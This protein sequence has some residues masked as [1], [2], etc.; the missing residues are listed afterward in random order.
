MST[1]IDQMIWKYC[2][3]HIQ[4][5]SKEIVN[6]KGPISAL[7]P[8][9]PPPQ[10]FSGPAQQRKVE[11]LQTTRDLLVASAVASSS[12]GEINRSAIQKIRSGVDRQRVEAELQSAEALT[13][14]ALRRR[15]VPASGRRQPIASTK[16]PSLSEQSSTTP[17]LIRCDSAGA[18]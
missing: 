12:P 4:N 6:Y 17:P 11:R 8:K 9:R 2:S 18:K 13:V 10:Q 5:N 15:R 3:Q 7:L 1:R 16:Q 14:E